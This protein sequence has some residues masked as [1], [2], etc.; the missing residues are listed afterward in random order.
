MLLSRLFA[1]KTKLS[2]CFMVVGAVAQMVKVRARIPFD[3]EIVRTTTIY[4][5]NADVSTPN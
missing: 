4:I 3:G 2:M 5:W 1:V